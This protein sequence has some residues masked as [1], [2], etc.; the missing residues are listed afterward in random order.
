VRTYRCPHEIKGEG[1]YAFVVLHEGEVRSEAVRKDLVKTVREQIGAF[2]APD[3]IHWT[4]GDAAVPPPGSAVTLATSILAAAACSHAWGLQVGFAR[5][6]AMRSC[7][8]G[9]S[10][11]PRRHSNVSSVQHECDLSGAAAR[12]A[13]GLPKTRSGKI[14][15]RILRKIA[16]KKDDELG[17]ITTLA[18]PAVVEQIISMRGK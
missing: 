16:M 8:A 13:A 14:M 18:D 7:A 5:T 3:V 12:G 10:N 11:A 1:I 15:R 4:P 17:D 6:G 9:A 2:A